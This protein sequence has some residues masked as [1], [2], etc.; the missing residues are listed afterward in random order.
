MDV[1]AFMLGKGTIVDRTQRYTL[2]TLCTSTITENGKQV[3]I[4]FM[5]C[6]YLIG[7]Y[8]ILWK[9]SNPKRPCVDFQFMRKLVLVLLQ[10]IQ[11]L[12]PDRGWY[13]KFFMVW[14][15]FF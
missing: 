4:V 10:P 13:V 3:S 14:Y 11:G 8:F 5:E 2:K 6:L 1:E 7:M 9:F 15:R 12:L